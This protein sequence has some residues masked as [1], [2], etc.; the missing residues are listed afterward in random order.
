M[1]FNWTEL[2]DNLSDLVFEEVYERPAAVGTH[3]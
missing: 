1:K 2:S 3:G